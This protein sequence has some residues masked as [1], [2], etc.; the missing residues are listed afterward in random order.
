MKCNDFCKEHCSSTRVPSKCCMQMTF[1]NSIFH[2]PLHTVRYAQVYSLKIFHTICDHGAKDGCEVS[3][4]NS[5]WQVWEAGWYQLA[6]GRCRF[7]LGTPRR[8]ALSSISA[9]LLGLGVDLAAVCSEGCRRSSCWYCS[10]C[11][12]WLHVWRAFNFMCAGSQREPV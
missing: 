2:I 3:C 12:A 7:S 10:G 8:T 11:G 5:C 1:V 9:C 4:W 6:M